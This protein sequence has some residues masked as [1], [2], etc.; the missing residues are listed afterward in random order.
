MRTAIQYCQYMPAAAINCFQS[1]NSQAALASALHFRKLFLCKARPF[2]LRFSMCLRRRFYCWLDSRCACDEHQY[3]LAGGGSV[4][5]ETSFHTLN[6]SRTRGRTSGAVCS[7]SRKRMSF[8]NS[9]SPLS[10]NHDSIGMPLSTCMVGAPASS[11]SGWA[12]VIVCRIGAAWL[13]V[14]WPTL[15]HTPCPRAS[16]LVP[17]RVR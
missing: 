2:S 12:S 8:S 4:A 9:V 16:H 5:S 3:E 6:L 7:G 15:N 17:E 14:R 13:S 10:S 11:N 1:L